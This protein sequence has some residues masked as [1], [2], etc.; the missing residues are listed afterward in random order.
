MPTYEYKCK[1]C[2]NTFEKFQSI[3]ENPIKN[4]KKCEGEVYRLISKNGNFILKGSGFYRTDYHHNN[5]NYKSEKKK[6]DSPIKPI[7]KE[8][9]EKK[10]LPKNLESETSLKKGNKL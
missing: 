4:C 2:G 5:N 6:E 8:E 1:K 10:E 3:T 7:K 9:P